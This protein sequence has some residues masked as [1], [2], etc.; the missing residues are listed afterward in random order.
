MVRL[1]T[2]PPKSERSVSNLRTRDKKKSRVNVLYPGLA[3]VNPY[4]NQ[5]TFSTI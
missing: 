1:D 2:L 3:N 5:S 4:E